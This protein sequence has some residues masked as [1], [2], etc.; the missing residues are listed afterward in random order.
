MKQQL[1][2]DILDI[3]IAHRCK[4]VVTAKVK[5]SSFQQY[6]GVPCLK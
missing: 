6:T 4:L 1:I 5:H 2:F 3:G